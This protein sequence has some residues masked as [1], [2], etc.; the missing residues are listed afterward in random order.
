MFVIGNIFHPGPI[1]AGAAF[2]RNTCQAQTFDAIN[3]YDT[4]VSQCR[5]TLAYLSRLLVM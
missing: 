5:N 2:L 1:F 3:K 4:K